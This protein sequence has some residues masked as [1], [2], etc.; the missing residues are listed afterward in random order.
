MHTLRITYINFTYTNS[1]SHAHTQVHMHTLRLTHIHI[2]IF[3]SKKTNFSI[4][5]PLGLKSY[6]LGRMFTVHPGSIA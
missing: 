5:E 2:K 1:G 3:K 6:L 4:H